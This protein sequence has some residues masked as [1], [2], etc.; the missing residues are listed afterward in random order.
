MPVIKQSDSLK[1]ILRCQLKQAWGRTFS[2]VTLNG[3][4]YIPSENK[5]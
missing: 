5:G 4:N 2:S 1:L 3:S